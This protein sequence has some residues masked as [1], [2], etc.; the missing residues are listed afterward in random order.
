MNIAFC[1]NDSGLRGLAVTISSLIKNC[2][3]PEKLKLWF[4]CAGLTEQTKEKIGEFILSIGYRISFKFVDF[5]PGKV[6]GSYRSLHGDWTTYGR[7]L[8]PD[9]I[10][11]DQVL[12]LD[13]DLV[14]ELD[15]L[16]IQNFKFNKNQFLAA[17]GGGCFQYT[18]GHK[19]Y[20]NQLGISPDLEYF[21]AG[22]LLINL[23]VWR[24]ANIKNKIFS[25]A[26]QYGKELPSHD[27]S[28]LNIIC[29]G[30]FARL[31]SSFNCCWIADQPKPE[32]SERMILHFIGAPKPWDPLGPFFHN[33]FRTWKRYHSNSSIFNKNKFTI[34]ELNRLWQ[35]R[36]SYGRSVRNRLLHFFLK[37]KTLILKQ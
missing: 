8:V 19:F 4:W 27:Q 10:P 32:I 2:S 28:I 34:S 14:V 21:N 33:G 23:K 15:V 36:R 20:L 3:E 11:G 35:L 30:D 31:P 16:E 9:A 29:A 18:L 37:S 13:S 26:D 22:V 5:D 7:L 12:Y 25:I 6:F 1:I 24:D 17:V